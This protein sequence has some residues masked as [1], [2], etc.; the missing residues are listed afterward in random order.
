MTPEKIKL[1][2]RLM[3]DPDLPI[4]EICRTLDVSR[5]TLYR[6]VG[7]GG[8]IRSSALRRTGKPS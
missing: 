7:P 5:A 3:G 2:A 8:E 1:A 4:D 6:H